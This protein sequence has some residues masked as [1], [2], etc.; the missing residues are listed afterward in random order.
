MFDRIVA[1]KRGK[2]NKFYRISAYFRVK[3]SVITTFCCKF[4]ENFQLRAKILLSITVRKRQKGEAD[5]TYDKL[6]SVESDGSV[7]TIAYHHPY[8]CMSED[9]RRAGS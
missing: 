9:F 4:A 6:D 1:L 7:H 8:T 2:I 3:N 5:K